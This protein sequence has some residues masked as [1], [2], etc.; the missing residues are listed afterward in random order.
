MMMD[1]F[2]RVEPVRDPNQSIRGIIT[3]SST[4]SG[5]GRR[6]SSASSPSEATETS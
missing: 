4:R 6:P 3:S 2:V 5:A 1:V